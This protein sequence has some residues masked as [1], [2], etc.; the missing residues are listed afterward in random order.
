MTFLSR[1]RRWLVLRQASGFHGRANKPDDSC[2]TFW[3]GASLALLGSAGLVDA[4][5][6]RNFTLA[7][8]DL[9]SGGFAKFSDSH[10]G[11]WA[12]RARSRSL[13]KLTILETP[14]IRT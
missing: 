8:Q 6:A 10:P 4:D 11:R 9:V 2:Y 14:S 7:C 3:I 5:A 1:L 12:G 13:S